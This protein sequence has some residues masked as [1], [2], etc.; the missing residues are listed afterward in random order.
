MLDEGDDRGCVCLHAPLFSTLSVSKPLLCYDID[1]SYYTQ[2]MFYSTWELSWANSLTCALC[3]NSR[4]KD[5]SY[6]TLIICVILN[7]RC[8]VSNPR[9]ERFE[10]EFK[11]VA[12]DGEY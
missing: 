5:N 6:A 1:L 3:S 11:F 7:K 9:E 8:C 4:E 2:Q 10:F 12:H